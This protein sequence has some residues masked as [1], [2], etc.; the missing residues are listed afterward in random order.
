MLVVGTSGAVQPAAS[1]GL[2]AKRAGAFVAEVNRSKTPQTT[3]FDVSLQGKAGELLP[4][5]VQQVSQ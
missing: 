5:L 1:F 2:V 3:F 4:Q